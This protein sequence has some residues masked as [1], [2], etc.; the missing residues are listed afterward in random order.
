[1]DNNG[2]F[3]NDCGNETSNDCLVQIHKD[4]TYQQHWKVCIFN[5]PDTNT[6]LWNE[7][8]LITIE[9]TKNEGK[10]NSKGQKVLHTHEFFTN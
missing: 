8:T 7:T 10:S 2:T 4:K 9:S 6:K 5:A 3:W 1:M